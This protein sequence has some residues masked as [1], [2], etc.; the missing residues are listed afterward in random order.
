MSNIK[1]VSEVRFHGL[2]DDKNASAI[3]RV[4]KLMFVATDEP[5]SEG[6]V[7]QVFRPNDAD[8]QLDPARTIL[9]DPSKSDKKEMDI[10]G[11]A[12]DGQT[13]YV[14]GSH[15]AKRKK[16]DPEKSYR[17][18]RKSLIS[19]VEI[20]PSRDVLLRFDWHDDDEPLQ[21]ERTTLRDVFLET[22]PFASFQSNSSKENGIDIEG[23][24][25][26][27]G[28][29][30]VGFRGPVLR[31]NF[32]VVLKFGFGKPLK[33][34]TPLFVNLGGRGIRDLTSVDQGLLI[35]AGPVGDGPGSYQIYFWDGRDGVPGSDAPTSVNDPGLRFIDNF[36]AIEG[37]DVVDAI[38]K[39]E[40]MMK[41]NENDRHWE[42]LIV[43]DGLKN[44][45]ALKLQVKKPRSP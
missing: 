28:Q 25:V 14:I 2:L 12:T 5:T 4:D 7:V 20:Q 8:F 15:S 26:Y 41:L 36:P 31:G 13:V 17:T 37:T 16:I 1:I 19:A 44:G 10:E 33:K 11:L 40:G 27:Q 23:I 24:A 43:C 29:V 42:L 9:L 38:P 21:I 18:N 32:A 34:P 45:H 22:E 30:Y 3:C 6:N 35:L 39:P